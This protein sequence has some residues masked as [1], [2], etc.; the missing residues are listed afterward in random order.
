MTSLDPL[1]RRSSHL[2]DEA[3]RLKWGSDLSDTEN[4]INSE[5]GDGIQEL[6]IFYAL[7]FFN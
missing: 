4:S 5:A 6:L 7:K 2:V 3:L 1:R